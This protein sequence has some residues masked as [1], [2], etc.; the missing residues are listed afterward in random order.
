MRLWMVRHAAVLQP[1]GICYGARDVPAEPV[2]TATAA[3]RLAE[4]LPDAL[5]VVCS[6]LQRCTALAA[7]LQ[8]RRPSLRLRI[9]ARLAEMD[10]GDWEG[11]PWDAIG[12]A[13]ISAW[14][15]DFRD[16]R[17]GGGESLAE[18][19]ARVGSAW[20]EALVQDDDVLWITHAGVIK[21]AQQLSAGQGDITRADQWPVQAVPHGEW[22]VLA[23]PAPTGR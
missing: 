22:V 2:A 13:A 16:H 14:T 12:E 6:P 11:Q 15:A 20:R 5:R 10:F 8:M 4:A 7:Q 18:V 3:A 1:G 17:P 19:M 9:D 23:R 21:A